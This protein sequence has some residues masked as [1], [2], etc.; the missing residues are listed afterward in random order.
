[1]VSDDEVRAECIE[2]RLKIGEDFLGRDRALIEDRMLHCGDVEMYPSGQTSSGLAFGSLFKGY[3]LDEVCDIK[4]AKNDRG[5][6]TEA[7]PPTDFPVPVTSV[8]S[9]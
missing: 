6:G 2:E 5:T 7:G 4:R 8:T 1:M 9:A 3:E